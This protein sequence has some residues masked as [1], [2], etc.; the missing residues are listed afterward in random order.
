M[1]NRK[2]L[3]LLLCLFAAIFG[4]SQMR[5]ID[6]INQLISS[7]DAQKLGPPVLADSTKVNWLNDLYYYHVN[8]EP[9]KALTYSKQAL[10]LAEKIDFRKGLALT[11]NDLGV[12]YSNQGKYKLAFYHLHKAEQLL[13]Q[14]QDDNGLANVYNSVGVIYAKQGSYPE[15]MSYA[16]KALKV[17][18]K[19]KDVLSAA[20]TIVNIGILYKHQNDFDNALKHYAKAMKLYETVKNEDGDFGRAATYNNIGQAYLKQ[21]KFD[22]SLEALLKSDK[23]GAYIDS[24]YLDAENFQALGTNYLYKKAYD[25]AMGYYQTAI[26]NFIEIGDNSGIANCLIN[27]GYC[28]FKKGNQAAAIAETNR[29]LA[30]AKELEQLEW[31]KDAYQ[32]LAEVYSTSGNYE[33]AYQNHVKYKEVADLMFNT[34]KEKKFTQ[35]Q[36]LYDF[37]KIQDSQ[38]ETQLRKEL[39]LSQETAKQRTIK[40]I[41][42]WILAAL[43][44]LTVWIYFNLKRN[45]KQK[46]IIASQKEIVEKQ[47]AVISE[48]LSEKETLLREIHHRVKN[49]L[50][51]I[52]SLLNIQSQHIKDAN[53]LSSIQEGQSRV[54]AMSLIHQNLY[55]SEQLNNVD[56]DNYLRELVVYLSDMFGGAEKS[57]DVEV[58]VSDIRFDIDTAIPLGLIVNELVSNAYKYA[59]E[60]RAAGKIQIGIRALNEVE[61]EL[62]VNDNGNGLPED[63]DPNTST[64]LGLK[65]VSI[66]SRQLRGKM[67]SHSADGTSFIISFKDMKA[68]QSSVS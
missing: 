60:N 36:M 4:Y 13:H 61:Y 38:E 18:E 22:Q 55:Q 49:N 28:H 56:I 20:G 64:S 21:G 63:F 39:L 50:Q 31:Q 34:E 32:N 67:R 3:I 12:L 30:L 11:H 41:V 43:A 35:L 37:N 33:L 68:Y 66:L 54:Q 24:P 16:T 5:K 47:N 19:Q 15:S 7:F 57:I 25:K 44:L 23:V 27:I 45:Q 58:E 62:N 17:Y 10:L 42:M 53:V 6:S 26:E 29:G 9:D 2:K 1:G 14:L 51:I 48:S 8:Y 40:Y 52:S 59:F 46:A 65:L